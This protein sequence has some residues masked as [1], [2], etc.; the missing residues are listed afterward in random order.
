MATKR[1][2][3]HDEGCEASRRRPCRRGSRPRPCSRR[4]RA[5]RRGAAHRRD[6]AHRPGPRRRG[7]P[8]GR[9]AMTSDRPRSRGR[10]TPRQP[11]AR[12]RWRIV[13][14]GH[15]VGVAARPA[16]RRLRP[17]WRDRELLGRDRLERVAEHVRVLE[18]DVREEHDPGGAGRSSRRGGR[19]G[20]PRRRRRRPARAANSASAAAVTISNCVASSSSAATRTRADGL[21]E[22]RLGAVHPDPLAPAG[23]VRRDRRSRRESP[24]ESR[25]CS[26]VD[27][28]PSTC[29]SCRRRGSRGT[30]LRIAEPASSAR[31]RSSPKPSRGHG[32][33]ARRATRPPSRS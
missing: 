3:R 14:T 15:E 6:C 27:A 31:I 18:P 21:L 10:R 1:A 26:I 23:D 9:G 33:D 25:S 20:R 13:A 22:V 24:S 28:S 19:R 11:R 12:R 17:V 32:R 16:G 5:V 29:R 30:R 2:T 4:R 7:A 8:T